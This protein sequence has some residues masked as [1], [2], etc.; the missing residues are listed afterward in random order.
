[1]PPE[2]IQETVTTTWLQ[3]QFKQTGARVTDIANETGIDRSQLSG[4]KLGRPMSTAAKAFFYLYF[5]NYGKDF[6]G[7]Q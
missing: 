7:S 4:W 1:M 3:E 6:K 5:K 2:N